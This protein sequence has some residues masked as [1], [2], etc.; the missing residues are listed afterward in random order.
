MSKI[1]FSVVTSRYI[2]DIEYIKAIKW[3]KETQHEQRYILNVL[4]SR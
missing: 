2:Q 1:T 4:F 3:K